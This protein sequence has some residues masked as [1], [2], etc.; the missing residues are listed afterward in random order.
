MSLRHIWPLVVV[1]VVSLSLTGCLQSAPPKSPTTNVKPKHV[2]ASHSFVSIAE[3][4]LHPTGKQALSVSA[5]LVVNQQNQTLTVSVDA[6]HLT[7]N[8][9]YN[10]YLLTN[11]AGA[12]STA[13]KLNHLVAN[14]SGEATS[15]TVVKGISELPDGTWRL[16]VANGAS[17]ASLQII[18]SGTAHLISSNSTR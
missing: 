17:S 12:W 1:S 11:P 18:A 6:V 15:M 7:P 14:T 3:T 9:T 2:T 4:N 10:V 5:T 13:K 16:G 8:H